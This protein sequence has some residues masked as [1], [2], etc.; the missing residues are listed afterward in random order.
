MAASTGLGIDETYMVAAGRV[1]RLGYFDH[2]PASWWLA[3]A[4]SRL[5][6]SEAAFVV[7]LPFIALFALTTWLM[8]R[9]GCRLYGAR[10]GLFAA[11]ALNLSPEFGLTTGTWVLPDG[12]LI[13]ALLGA[14]LCLT[15]A[16]DRRG[17]AWWLGT[18][19]CLGLALFSKYSAILT[20]SGAFLYLLT[21]TRHRIWLSRPQPYL[22]VTVAALVFSPVI[23]WNIQHGWASFAFQGSRATAGARLHPWAP[24]GVLG[25]EALFVLPWIWLP[26]ILL[27]ARAV[28]RGPGIVADWL[29]ACLAAPPIL[30][31]VAV[32]A[33]S[34][35]RVLFHWAAPGYLML[36]PMLGD[37]IA[38]TLPSGHWHLRRT[39]LATAGL[40]VVALAVLVS[41]VRWNWLPPLKGGDP[42]LDAVDW[43][44]LRDQMAARG[45][46]SPGMTLAGVRWQDCGKLDYAWHGTVPLVCLT[47]D[48]RQYGMASAPPPG[49][50]LILAPRT[51]P[52]R[53][54]AELGGR[55]RS[56]ETLPPAAVLHA[57]RAALDVPVYIGRR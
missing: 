31:F 6:G 14:A 47:G 21:S 41:D 51:T 27:L 4:A 16:L 11:V 32:S 42:L 9:L 10:A 20:L 13:C 8:F 12:P 55:F 50:V 1:F 2:P 53:M 39:M 17:T 46:P 35:Q 15:H 22:A 36:F 43:T 45:L 28:R 24:L 5:A 7:R 23:I 34:S 19:L 52:E 37:W 26:M 18:G 40:I 29:G 48:A 33:W 30:L 3:T 25:G 57:G 49:D 44:S 56:I 54:A 38:R